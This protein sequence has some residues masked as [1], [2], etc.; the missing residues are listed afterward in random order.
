MTPIKYDITVILEYDS[1]G[2]F[3]CSKCPSLGVLV[4]HH[5]GRF[6]RCPDCNTLCSVESGAGSLRAASSPRYDH[7][8]P[9]PRTAPLT[10]VAL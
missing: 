1:I 8:N 10:R 3:A 5:A 2:L 6:Y 9:A 7:G 4:N